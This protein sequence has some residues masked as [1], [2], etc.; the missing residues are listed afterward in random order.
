MDKYGFI[1]NQFII[2]D[3]DFNIIEGQHRL[4]AAKEL[5]IDLYYTI[6][7]GNSLELIKTVNNI[8]EKWKI[9]DWMNYY[10]NLGCPEY[11]KLKKKIDYLGWPVSITMK[12]FSCYSGSVC[13]QFKA[14][15]YRFISNELIEKSVE[16]S[17]ELLDLLEINGLIETRQKY[18]TSLHIALKYFLC[19]TCVNHE[20]FKEKIKRCPVPF[21]Q[22]NDYR[23][24]VENMLKIYN[25]QLKTNR[26][27]M[28]IDGKKIK[29]RMD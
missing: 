14:G 3:K 18:N 19:N 27:S 23:I 21:R 12:W 13:S 8:R 6:Y 17:K 5:G 24:N 28:G 11:I 26:L 29:I 10:F 16:T 20:L 7:Q 22:S 15:Q 25:Y 1:E 4:E 2:V 9:K